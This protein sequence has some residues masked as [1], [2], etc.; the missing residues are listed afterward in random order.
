MIRKWIV[1]LFILSGVLAVLPLNAHATPD[2]GIWPSYGAD[3]GIF[4]SECDSNNNCSCP[5]DTRK[6]WIRNEGDSDLTVTAIS[7]PSSPFS[8]VSPPAVPFTLTPGSEL[9]INISFSPVSAGN[10]SST[11]DISSDDPDESN[12]GVPLT[13]IVDEEPVTIS[14][15][16]FIT[17]EIALI[18]A[19]TDNFYFYGKQ[20]DVVNVTTAMQN[21]YTGYM[22][23]RWELYDPNGGL[24]NYTN[25][26]SKTVT[27][28]T[29]GTYSILIRDTFN[30]ATGRYGL[31][32]NGVSESLQSGKNIGFAQ[33]YVDEVEALGDT[34]TFLFTGAQDDTIYVTTAMQNHYTGYMY[35]R[36]ELYDPNGGLV[37]Y[38]NGGSKT[39]TLPTT[40]TY[41]ILIRDTFNGA[42]GRYGLS[43][44]CV[45]C[46]PDLIVSALTVSPLF[47]VPGSTVTV[48][49]TIKNQKGTAGPSTTKFYFSTDTTY[50][51]EDTYL[52]SR[53]IPS[54][55][56]GGTSTGSTSV[57]IPP[58]VCCAADTY[59]IIAVADAD[60]DV[61][62]SNEANNVK[63]KP[64]SIGPDLIENYLSA[65]SSAVRG[66]TIT[67]TDTTKNQGED[68]A[69]ASKTKFYLS[70]DT[71]LNPWDILLSPESG[72]AVPSLLPG[73]KSKGSTNVTIPL[74]IPDGAYYIIAVADAEGDVC[75]ANE[76]NNDNVRKAIT[77]L[78]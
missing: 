56:S 59:Y 4:I 44:Q 76:V 72:R 15:G 3:S 2:I 50:S 38:T 12:L 24:V 8:L 14:P 74:N 13:G 66:S 77:I 9:D 11:I 71:T 17:G 52:G 36:W 64:V 5:S 69:G 18:L 68:T 20:N 65:P 73:N 23:P 28:P 51:A 53:D 26:G 41:T 10:Y 40:G 29:T 25:G 33:T 58:S 47:V 6:V 48:T 55:A 63:S 32:L 1:F 45:A 21:H 62:E 60:N 43:L 70:T 61:S 57:T 42:T 16:N 19:D 78:P 37:D 67:V 35:P 31:S 46:G 7:N 30:S 49:D 54:L 22:Y 27:L 39:V 34:D 75:E